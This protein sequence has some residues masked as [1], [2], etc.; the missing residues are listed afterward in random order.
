MSMY[1]SFQIETYRT[2]SASSQNCCYGNIVSEI[3]SS[4]WKTELLATFFTFLNLGSWSLRPSV[5]EDFKQIVAPREQEGKQ[6]S[7][8]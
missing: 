4:S 6:I 1:K 8:W 3:H 5:S 7:Y 2:P